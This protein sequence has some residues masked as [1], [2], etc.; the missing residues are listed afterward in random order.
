MFL[1]LLFPASL[2]FNINDFKQDFFNKNFKSIG[3]LNGLDQV[4]E[5]IKNNK[6]SMYIFNFNDYYLHNAS[7]ILFNTNEIK[8]L[9]DDNQNISDESDFIYVTADTITNYP[10]FNRFN[11]SAI[12]KF[13]NL[14][15]LLPYKVISSN[16][17]LYYLYKS[18]NNILKTDKNSFKFNETINFDKNIKYYP[19]AFTKLI[20]SVV[21]RILFLF[22]MILILLITL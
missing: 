4:I 13:K 16:K 17:N 9:Y 18:K 6:S 8:L 1:F 11:P 20:L 19:L 10:L 5:Y 21:T 3:S 14:Y 15:Y 7:R 2:I 22:L 12:S